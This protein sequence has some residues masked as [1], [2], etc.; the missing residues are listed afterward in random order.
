M[1]PMHCDCKRGVK[2]LRS[3]IEPL[4]FNCHCM[5]A[6]WFQSIWSGWHEVLQFSTRWQI[7]LGDA[8]ALTIP[9]EWKFNERS[10]CFCVSELEISA[11][12]IQNKTSLALYLRASMHS[13]QCQE[14]LTTQ[15]V[16]VAWNYVF[17]KKWQKHRKAATSVSEDTSGHVKFH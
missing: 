5:W 9:S 14:I 15:G 3:S 17:D 7:L 11:W 8:K 16:F 1:L 13:S 4:P 12:A 10:V 6:V 2:Q